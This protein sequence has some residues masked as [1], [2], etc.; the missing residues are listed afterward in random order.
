MSIA[1]ST[2]PANAISTL[3]DLV[4]EIRDEMDDS[5]YDIPRIYRAITRAEAIFNREIRAPRMETATTLA[6]AGEATDLPLDFLQLRTAYS[7][8]SPDRPMHSLSPNALRV[9]YQGRAGVPVA[10]AIEN[11]SFIVGPVGEVSVKLLYYAMIP[12]L[13]ADNPANWLLAEHPDLYV[14]QSLAILFNKTG[15][16]E[17]A[18]LNQTIARDIMDQINA[19]TKKAR[20]GAS[21]LSPMGIQQVY[22]TR[23]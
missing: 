21:P 23:I 9:M 10:Y 13:T 12:A 19:A 8:G 6:V 17:R 11:R 20:W 16:S 15:D 2:N 3:S 7:D 4:E 22:G 5:S 1:I 18:A 14:H